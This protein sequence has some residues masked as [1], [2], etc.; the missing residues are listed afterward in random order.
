MNGAG[1]RHSR[2]IFSE[3]RGA[4]SV[5]VRPIA[6]GGGR[7]G[8]RIIGAMASKMPPGMAEAYGRKMGWAVAAVALLLTANNCLPYLGVRLDGCQTMFS[9]LAF[10]EASNNHLLIPQRTISDVGDCRGRREGPLLTTARRHPAGGAVRLA[11]ERPPRLPPGGA[12]PRR[13]TGCAPAGI[14]IELAYRTEADGGATF[15]SGDAC[16]TVGLDPPRWW[17]PF[18]LFPPAR[19]RQ[20]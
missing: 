3:C 5:G 20:R 7:G 19:P 8:S 9:G 4:G 15:R 10:T 11:G 2:H 18:R 17:L 13:C 12:A 16:G 14:S 1:S 6:A